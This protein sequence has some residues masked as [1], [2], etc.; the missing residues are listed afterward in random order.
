M[1]ERID[2][3]TREGRTKIQ[4]R[5]TALTDIHAV[6]ELEMNEYSKSRSP[7]CWETLVFHHACLQHHFV[8]HFH[9]KNESFDQLRL[10]GNV[11]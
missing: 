8:W 6:H 7:A 2:K 4:A 11:S 3:T 9:G 10:S 5:I 1:I